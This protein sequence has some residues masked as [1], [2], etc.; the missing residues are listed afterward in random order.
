[1]DGGNFRGEGCWGMA[2]ERAEPD[3]CLALGI[4]ARVV[5]RLKKVVK[6]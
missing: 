5:K 3:N 1:M 6:Q 4:P 2:V